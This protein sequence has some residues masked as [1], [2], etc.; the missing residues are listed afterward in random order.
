MELCQGC[1]WVWWDIFIIHCYSSVFR[2]VVGSYRNSLRVDV[3]LIPT[4]EL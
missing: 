2:K 4:V 3:I 1:P